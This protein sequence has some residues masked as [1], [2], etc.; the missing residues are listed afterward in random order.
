MHSYL[1]TTQTKGDSMHSNTINQM[2]N[3]ILTL[4]SRLSHFGLCPTEW[5]LIPKKDNFLLIR[6]KFEQSFYFLGE[7]QQKERT[8][9]PD[10]K[11]ITL[12]SL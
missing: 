3:E 12:I 2:G 6:N 11:F 10:W 9:K 8:E 1:K 4:Q 7:T 5:D